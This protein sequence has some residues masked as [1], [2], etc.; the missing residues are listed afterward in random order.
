MFVLCVLYSK[1]QNAKSGQSGQ[2]S[3]DKVH[4]EKKYVKA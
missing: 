4:R 1:E 3:T 2:R